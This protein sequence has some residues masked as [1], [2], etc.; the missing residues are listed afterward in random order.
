MFL[1]LLKLF[2]VEI[3]ICQ[4]SLRIFSTGPWTSE[5]GASR[6]IEP[7]QGL[8]RVWMAK[9]SRVELVVVSPWMLL[10]IMSLSHIT[11]GIKNSASSNYT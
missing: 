8:V 10:H 1:I 3:H 2:S 5:L 7:D 4:K 11:R 9:K 6:S